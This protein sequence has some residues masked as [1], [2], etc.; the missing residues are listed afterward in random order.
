[1]EA[2]VERLELVVNALVQQEVHITLHI[3]CKQKQGSNYNQLSED[4]YIFTSILI[5]GNNNNDCLKSYYI[6]SCSI[7]PQPRKIH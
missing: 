1:M 7:F 4:I 2:V 6:T 3:V 5:K